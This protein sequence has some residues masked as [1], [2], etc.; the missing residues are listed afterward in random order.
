MFVY[1]GLG[2]GKLVIRELRLSFVVFQG[3][4]VVHNFTMR[5]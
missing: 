4:R 2:V 3:L 5:E 1:V